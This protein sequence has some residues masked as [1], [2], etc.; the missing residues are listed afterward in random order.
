MVETDAFWDF[1]WEMR[2]RP[3]ENLGKRAAIQAASR[4]MRQMA[5]SGR[6]SGLRLLELGCG[7]GQILGALVDGHAQLCDRRACVGVDY[8]PRSL[9]RCRQDYPGLQWLEDDFTSAGYLEALGRFDLVLM[10]NALHEVF[11]STLSAGVVDV[12]AAKQRAET[13]LGR[14]A[15]CLG[16]GGW[17]VLFDGLEPPGDPRESLRVRF[18]NAASRRDFETFARQYRPFHITYRPGEGPLEVEL[19]RRHFTRYIT[20]SIFL[21]KSL[22]QTERLESYQYFTQDEF[23]AAF[24]RQGLVIR[25]E[26]TLTMNAVKWEQRVTILT[27][28]VGF[29]EEHILILAQGAAPA[30]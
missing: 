8:N 27:P 29:P 10:V 9:E 25:E 28:G 17:L 16:A 5:R 2:L 4:L 11:S 14:A 15:A 26:R 3:M 6:G 21:G 23:H 22:W 20:K 1:F 13:T 30:Q 18:A 12:P 7:E 24:E 19:P